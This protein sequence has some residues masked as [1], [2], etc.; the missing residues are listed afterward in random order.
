VPFAGSI[1]FRLGS[2]LAA[3]EIAAEAALEAG[4]ERGISALRD[5]M[6]AR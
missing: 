5:Y 2:G 3:G 4:G 6:K 1:V